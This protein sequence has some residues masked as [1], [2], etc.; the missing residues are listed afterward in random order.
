MKQPTLTRMLMAEFLGTL[1]LMMFGLGVNAQVELSGQA[2]GDFFTVNI[3]WGL[4]VMFGVYCSGGISGA[5]LNP[6]VT[7]ALAVWRKFP[8]RY[9]IPYIVVQVLAAFV[10][11]GLIYF[12]Y[13]EA[14]NTYE[15]KDE[16]VEAS[17]E[18]QDEL[19]QEDLDN[20][21][22]TK[23]T[24]GIWATYPSD[25]LRPIRGGLMDQIVGTGLLLL[26]IFALSD[27]KNQAPADGI[28]PLMVG[29]IV[30]AIGMTFGFNCGYAINPARDFGPRLFT[31]LAGWGPEVFTRANGFWWVPVVGPIIGGVIGGALYDIFVT[32]W[33]PQENE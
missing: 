27:K 16:I 22:R 29:S 8:I 28:A 19:S 20:A 33:H 12:T 5:H 2:K 10:A 25:H 6:A 15:M 30:A 7:I 3:G 13:I 18:G 9:V 14:I 11:S 32:H 24:A 31:Y 1:V 4:A 21:P 23:K 17:N 26:C